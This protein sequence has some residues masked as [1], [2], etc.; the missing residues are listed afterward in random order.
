MLILVSRTRLPAQSVGFVMIVAGAV[1]WLASELGG[2]RVVAAT[3]AAVII[4]V[5]LVCYALVTTFVSPVSAATPVVLESPVR[6]RWQAMNS[7]A[8]AMPSHGTHAYAQAFAVDLIALPEGE[9]H[10]EFGQADAAF[11][12]PA[13]FPAFGEPLFAPADGVVVAA[14]DDQRDHRSRSSWAAYA[15]F[16]L[17]SMIRE[18]RGPRGVLGNHLV[19]RL[20]DGTHFLMAHLQHGSIEVVRGDRVVAG[21]QVASCGNSGNST[22]PHLHAQ[23]MD[24]ADPFTAVSLPWAIAGAGPDGADVIPPN[25]AVFEAR[26]PT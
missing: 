4:G 1:T 22:E 14:R 10:P 5:A 23:L 6:G 21:Q 25:L 13:A 15:V 12:P 24:T 18:A 26:T 11:L 3:T 8:S 17:E 19:I 7:P 20:D 16:V 2:W 9:H